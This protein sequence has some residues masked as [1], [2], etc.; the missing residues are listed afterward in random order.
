MVYFL[1]YAYIYAGVFFFYIKRTTTTCYCAE[2]ERV[3]NLCVCVW[4]KCKLDTSEN[5]CESCVA[6]PD[7][8]DYKIIGAG[9]HCH[10]HVVKRFEPQRGGRLLN[11]KR[12]RE[13][14]CVCGALYYCL[15]LDKYISEGG[16]ARPLCIHTYNN[17]LF[18][19]RRDAGK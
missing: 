12:M 18:K 14:V 15:K 17:N 13:N 10:R 3:C 19:R 2:R 4:D 11:L 8:G 16:N 1:L 9:G 7:A 5:R 6:S